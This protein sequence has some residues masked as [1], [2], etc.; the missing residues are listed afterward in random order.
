MFRPRFCAAGVRFVRVASQA[1]EPSGGTSSRSGWVCVAVCSVSSTSWVCAQRWARTTAVAALAE[2]SGVETE[3]GVTMRTRRMYILT[4]AAV[5]SLPRFTH[6]L[7]VQ[8]W[9]VESVSLCLRM[10]SFVVFRARWVLVVLCC[11]KM[12]KILNS[13]SWIPVYVLI[14][15]H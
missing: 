15:I 5:S 9:L 13:S 2:G 14:Q 7:D 12:E 11:L 4:P 6:R 1:E 10:V 3:E 8:Q